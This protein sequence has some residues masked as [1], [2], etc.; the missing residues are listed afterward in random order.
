MFTPDRAFEI[1]VKSQIEKLL[2][3][4]LACVDMVVQELGSV[5]KKCGEGVSL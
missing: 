2:E 3:P 5:I 1:I 4:S